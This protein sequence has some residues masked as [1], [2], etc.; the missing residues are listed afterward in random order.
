[1]LVTANPPFGAGDCIFP[2]PAMT[3]SAIDRLVQHATI[4]EMNLESYRRRSAVMRGTGSE[5]EEG[6]AS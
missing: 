2:D 5:E 3:G 1:V 4:F 6:T